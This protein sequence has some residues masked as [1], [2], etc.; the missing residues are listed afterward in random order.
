MIDGVLYFYTPGGRLIALDPETGKSIWEYDSQPGVTS[1]RTHQHRGI[2]YWPAGGRIFTGT[3]D[4]KLIGLDI[5]TG[6]PAAGFG[7]NGVLDLRAGIADR[8]PKAAYAVTSPAAI[9]ENLVIV[10]AE[11]PE[12]FAIGPSGLVRAFDAR[13]GKLVWAFHTIPQ[14][15]EFGHETWLNSGWKDRTGVNVWSMM[16][17]DAKRGMVFLPIGSASYDFYGGDRPGNN[18]FA[19]SVV[20]LDARTGKRVWHYQL[21]HHDLWDY[22]LPAMPMLVTIDGKDAVVQVTKSAFV[23]VF[24]RAT[25]KPVF[26]IE[27]RPVPQSEVPGEKTSPTQPFPLKP[28][29]LA[30]TMVTAKDL[31]TVTPEAAKLCKD[32]FD[33]SVHKGI[34]TPWSDKQMTLAM[35]GTLGGATWSRRQL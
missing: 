20:A 27:E 5:K 2:S 26:P 21:I 30:R 9:F 18:L 34:F 14:P 15:G 11:V 23:F 1:R 12:G 32:L 28:P 29:P 10:G 4:G 7:D 6:K 19:N 35:P 17:V 8:W 24:D 16:S 3:M 31:S 22:D 13:S 33:Q 25:G